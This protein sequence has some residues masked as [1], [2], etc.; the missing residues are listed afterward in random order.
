LVSGPDLS[1]VGFVVEAF[2]RSHRFLKTVKMY[3]KALNFEYI[4]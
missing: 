2:E 4:D 1:I 3:G